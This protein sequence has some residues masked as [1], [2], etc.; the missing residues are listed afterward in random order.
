MSKRWIA[1]MMVV[2]LALTGTAAAQTEGGNIVLPQYTHIARINKS[3]DVQDGKAQCYASGRSR[4]ADTTTTIRV[5]LQRRAANETAWRYVCSWSDTQKGKAIAEVDAEK[6][7]AQG[8]DYR[9][10][11]KCTIRDSEGGIKETGSTY[12]N[13]VTY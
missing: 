10:Y 13:I 9:I 8:Y 6:T 7:V 5:T 4:Y 12:S 3:F 11:I 1:I 2:L